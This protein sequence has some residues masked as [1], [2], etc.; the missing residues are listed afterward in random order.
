M[1]GVTSP[2][3]RN[4]ETCA[5]SHRTTIAV[6]AIGF[7]RISTA[8]AARLKSLDDLD[9]D[10]DDEGDGDGGGNDDDD[11]DGEVNLRRGR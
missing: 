4:L 8:K 10:D 3:K 2:S 5:T 9:D 11:D 6:S 1:S 7:V